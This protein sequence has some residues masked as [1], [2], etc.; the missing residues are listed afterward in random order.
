LIMSRIKER[1]IG[2]EGGDDNDVRPITRLIDEMV[3][4]EMLA[5]TLQEAHQRAEDSVRAYYNTLTAK[6]FLDQHKRAFSHE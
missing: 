2:Y 4:Y 6:E 3:D 1:L 5:M